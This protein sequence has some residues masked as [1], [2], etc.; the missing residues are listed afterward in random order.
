MSVSPIGLFPN[1]TQIN[2]GYN[3]LQKYNLNS[4]NNYYNN[5]SNKELVNHNY[6]VNQNSQLEYE[7]NILPRKLRF[8]EVSHN[9]FN[10]TNKK[11]FIL[12]NL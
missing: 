4:N 12:F 10:I 2:S 3:D 7:A 8:S 6:N 9:N 5:N 1:Q 11:V